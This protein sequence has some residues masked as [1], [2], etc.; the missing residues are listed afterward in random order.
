MGRNKK[1]NLKLFLQKEGK[2][3]STLVIN[4]ANN[5]GKNKEDRLLQWS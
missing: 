2:K 1:F 4:F 3:L 5:L